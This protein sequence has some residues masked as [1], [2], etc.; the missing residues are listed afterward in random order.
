MAHEMKDV[1]RC[2]RRIRTRGPMISSPTRSPSDYQPQLPNRRKIFAIYLLTLLMYTVAGPDP[3]PGGGVNYLTLRVQF[4]ANE[5]NEGE[6]L[7]PNPN[8]C[9]STLTSGNSGGAAP[10]YTIYTGGKGSTT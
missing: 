5:C 3:N 8:E 6:T 10:T 9:I 2:I 7:T 4:Y 1:K